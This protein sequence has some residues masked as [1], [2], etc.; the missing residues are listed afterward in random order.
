MVEVAKRVINSSVF[1]NKP[2]L[3][4]MKKKFLFFPIVL[5]FAITVISCE[6]DA[7]TPKPEPET[8]IEE[9]TQKHVKKVLIEDYTATWCGYCP[10]IA[11][12]ID[13]VLSKSDKVVAVAVHSDEDMGYAFVSSMAYT[14]GIEGF[15]TGHI[16]RSFSWDYPETLSGLSSA[17]N[18]KAPLGI[19]LETSIADGNASITV[20]IEYATTITTSTKLV[21]YLTEDKII[22]NQANY[23]NDG[24]GNP[25]VGF[26]HN[27]VLRVAATD[28]FGDPISSTETV[29]DNISTHTFS[30]PLEGYNAENCHI[31]AFATAGGANAYN[32]QSVK[33]GSTKD[34]D[35]ITK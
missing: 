18:K 11:A 1:Y 20:K 32:V 31:V 16:D 34:F 33:L 5:L 19:K 25:I 26:E 12:A 7:P 35:Y 9:Y 24:R 30:I 13:D 27:H 8:P 15:P 28:I 22:A 4:L 2:K 10:R 14:Y 21:V 3:N 29:K 17:L 23:Y 6:E